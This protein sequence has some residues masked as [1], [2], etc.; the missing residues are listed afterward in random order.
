[1]SEYIFGRNAVLQ[2]LRAGTEVHRVLLARGTKRDGMLGEALRAARHNDIPVVEVERDALDRL[3]KRGALHQG[4]VAET[5]EFEYATL[6]EILELARAADEP[7]FLL[8]LDNVQ[9]VK[10]FGALLRTAEIVGAHGVLI[11]EHRQAGVTAEVRKASAG[12]VDFLKIAQVTNLAQTIEEL[13][14]QNIW[15]VGIEEAP[16]ALS[17]AQGDYT[18]PIAFVVGSE[19]DGLRRLTREKCDYL[20]QLPMWGK[21]PSLNVSVAGSIVLYHARQQRAAK[22]IGAPPRN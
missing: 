15:V 18:I 12:A 8:L 9:Y 5:G 6:D 10:N 16:N 11:P 1:M 22:G 2:A 17:Y 19:V 21:T 13:K 4:I 7:P 3:L 14:K 20:A